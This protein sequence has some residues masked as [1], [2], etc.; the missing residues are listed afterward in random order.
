[1][2]GGGR[3]PARGRDG[4]SARGRRG[5]RQRAGARRPLLPRA[6]DHRMSALVEL[7]LED[8]AARVR[9]RQVSSVE[10]T[11]AALDRIA[12]MEPTVGAFLTVASADALAAAE[13][14]DRRVAAGD[15]AGPLGGVPIGV[16]D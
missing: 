4:E 8:A 2:R 13:A 7:S 16:K 15:D 11:R 5:A 14:I 6:E 9:R 12:A 1:R 3:R 10:L